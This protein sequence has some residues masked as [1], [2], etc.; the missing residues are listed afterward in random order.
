MISRVLFS[1]I[2]QRTTPHFVTKL[3]STLV[4]VINLTI[5]QTREDADALIIQTA[6]NLAERNPDKI[7]DLA[8]L[9]IALTPNHL[10]IM[11]WKPHGFSKIT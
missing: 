3:K 11:M 7:I 9:V 2:T 10:N 8:A 4:A 5:K 6:I 1:I